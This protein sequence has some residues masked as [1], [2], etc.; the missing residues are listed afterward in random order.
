MKRTPLIRRSS[1]RRSYPQPWQRA[2]DDKVDPV[3]RDHVLRRDGGC[4]APRVDLE[5]GPCWGR[6]TLDHVKDEA[7]MGVRAESDRYHLVSVCQGHSEDGR[8]A[9]YQWNTSKEGRA[10]ERDYLAKKEPR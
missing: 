9:G 7:R 3:E 2:P 8:K 6:V 5:A 4:I 1:L 10:A